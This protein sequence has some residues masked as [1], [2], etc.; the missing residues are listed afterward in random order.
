V[1]TAVGKVGPARLT[2]ADVALEAGLTPGAIAQRFGSKRNLLLSF[3]RGSQPAGQFKAAYVNSP[4]EHPLDRLMEALLAICGAELTA[5]PTAETFAN[6]LAFLHLDL[7]DPE[8]RAVLV[9]QEH[10][11]RQSIEECL[12]TALVQGYLAPTTNVLEL[13][14]ALTAIRHGS[15]VSWAIHREVP[16]VDSLRRDLQTVLGP[17]RV[18]PAERVARTI[19]PERKH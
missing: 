2:L 19:K 7:A 16:L 4:M 10:Q 1:A 17:Y 12:S 6:H 5:G 11:L 13:T 9:E 14:F 8:F 3:V 15:Q 18:T